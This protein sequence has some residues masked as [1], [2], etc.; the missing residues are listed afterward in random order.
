MSDIDALLTGIPLDDGISRFDSID[1]V[2]NID[3]KSFLLTLH[4][5]KNRIIRRTFESLNYVVKN[6][7]RI[8]FAGINK[9]KLHPGKWRFLSEKELLK[10]KDFFK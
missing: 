9:L 2:D 1:F 3:K 10:I 8:S 5:G 6:L 7:D 4:S